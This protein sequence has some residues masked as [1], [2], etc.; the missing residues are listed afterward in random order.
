MNNNGFKGEHIKGNHSRERKP[1]S[2][3]ILKRLS[4]D[5]RFF[6]ANKKEENEW[7]F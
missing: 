1:I 4:S 7:N 6:N 2:N 5:K 3:N